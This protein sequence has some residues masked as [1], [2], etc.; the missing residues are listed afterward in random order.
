[1]ISVGLWLLNRIMLWD[2]WYVE[3]GF[4]VCSCSAAV[5]HGQRCA[6]AA[7]KEEKIKQKQK[8]KGIQKHPLYHW[9]EPFWTTTTPSPN[10]L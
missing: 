9:S 10:M 3:I 1:M 5:D 2:C 8:V 4:I 6:G 7:Q